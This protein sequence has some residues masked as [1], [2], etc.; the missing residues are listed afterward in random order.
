MDDDVRESTLAL[1]VNCRNAGHLL[2]LPTGHVDQPELAGLF[3]DE[4]NV[5]LGNAAARQKVHGPRSLE[6]RYL[7]GDERLSG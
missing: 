3:G 6:A 1:D 7:G 4:S 2:L 5:R